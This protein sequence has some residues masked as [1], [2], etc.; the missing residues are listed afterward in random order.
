MGIESGYGYEI[1]GKYRFTIFH[2]WCVWF[3]FYEVWCVI[4]CFD[5][6]LI[7]GQLKNILILI[8][9][10]TAIFFFFINKT[11]LP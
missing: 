5:S 9:I 1:N 2:L 6:L 8:S 10:Q 3:Y 7:D 11:L 4:V